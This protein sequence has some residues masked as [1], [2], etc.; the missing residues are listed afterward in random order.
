MPATIRIGSPPRDSRWWPTSSTGR[1]SSRC[2]VLT[3]LLCWVSPPPI[4]VSRPSRPRRLAA[5]VDDSHE[6]EVLEV[7][8]R[9]HARNADLR[10]D[11]VRAQRLGAAV[12]LNQHGPQRRLLEALRQPAAAAWRAGR[13]DGVDVRLAQL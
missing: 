11:V 5:H 13:A 3:L 12:E 4:A 8:A 10:A 1:T 6:R 7:A 9:G 2:L